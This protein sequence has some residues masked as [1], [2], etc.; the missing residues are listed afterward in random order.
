MV[1]EKRMDSRFQKRIQ[2]HL[3]YGDMADME[4]PS[5]PL[6][7]LVVDYFHD[8]VP[9]KLGHVDMYTAAD[10]I[11]KTRVSP[12]SMVLSMLYAKR[13][14]QTNQE[15]LRS[16]S[17]SDIFFISVMMASKYLYD[18]G[19]EEEVFND[20]WAD[21]TDQDVDYV[22]KL[23]MDF[24]KALDW[25]LFVKPDDFESTLAGVEKRLALQ[26]GLK[27]NW[28]TYS[29]LDLLLT[30]DTVA[31]LWYQSVLECSKVVSTLSAVYLTGIFTLLGSTALAIQVSGPLSAATLAIFSLSAQHLPVS[32]IATRFEP[33]QSSALQEGGFGLADVVNNV[34]GIVVENM[35]EHN[36]SAMWNTQFGESLAASSGSF[37][38]ESAVSER[39][40]SFSWSAWVVDSLLTQFLALMRYKSEFLKKSNS[41]AHNEEEISDTELKGSA[42]QYGPGTCHKHRN[43]HVRNRCLRKSKIHVASSDFTQPKKA[44]QGSPH[45]PWICFDGSHH[46]HI[47][48]VKLGDVPHLAVNTGA[49]AKWGFSTCRSEKA[50]EK[51]AHPENPV[52]FEDHLKLN[53][54]NSLDLAPSTWYQPVKSNRQV[55]THTLSFHPGFNH[56]VKV[57]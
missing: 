8:S 52:H 44:D 49:K 35:G 6:T 12:A 55:L 27:R 7:E 3:Y 18:E 26:E 32:N 24:L 53:C 5:F 10:I 46:C 25:R 20:E 54:V 11:R 23:E 47:D 15:Y 17:S 1:K 56:G 33:L 14:R 4:K 48:R 40:P 22:N 34:S 57:T 37:P 21:N 41:N 30:S 13:L 38:D 16:I 2:R 36:D 43:V 29:E 45:F 51:S 9:D 28:F 39:Q 42:S 31:S 50:K 19:V